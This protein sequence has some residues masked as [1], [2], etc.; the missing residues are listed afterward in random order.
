M[1]V[2]L[3]SLLKDNDNQLVVNIEF[4]SHSPFSGAAFINFNVKR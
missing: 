1:R 2:A 4:I 3:L